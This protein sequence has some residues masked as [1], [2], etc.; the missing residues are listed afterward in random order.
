MHSPTPQLS[1]QPFHQAQPLQLWG[2][3]LVPTVA[4]QNYKSCNSVNIHLTENTTFKLWEVINE[5]LYF[6]MKLYFLMFQLWVSG[7]IF[8]WLPIKGEGIHYKSWKA[9]RTGL[10][11]LSLRRW[12][13]FMENGGHIQLNMDLEPQW[14][15]PAFSL[16]KQGWL[17]KIWGKRICVQKDQSPRLSET[18]NTSQFIILS[19]ICNCSKQ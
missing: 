14:G 15:I 12:T 18:Q 1:D 19:G 7:P 16:H 9:N 3:P 5:S 8:P 11:L 13:F 10:H 6:I 4:K 2:H 17:C